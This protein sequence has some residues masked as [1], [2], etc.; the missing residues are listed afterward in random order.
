MTVITRLFA[1]VLLAAVLAPLAQASASDPHSV[2]QVAI[3]RMTQRIEQDRARLTA[4]PGYARR[5]VNEE[6][7]GLVDFRRITQLVMGQYFGPSSREQKIRFLEVFRASLVNTYASGLTLYEGQEVRVLPAASGDIADGRA[8]VRTEIRTNT[9]SVVPVFFSLY[10]NRDGVWMVEN[11]IVNGLNLGRT[12]RTQFEQS[13]RQRNGDLDQ[14][15]AN[16]SADIDIE[17]QAT[18]AAE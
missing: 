11:V 10:E 15:I 8:R 2:I 16:W 14:V 9:G 4:E 13:A 5:V 17:A 6:L 18:P 7:D 12:F 3:E 1:T